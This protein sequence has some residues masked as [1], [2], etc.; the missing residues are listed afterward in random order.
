MIDPAIRSAWV[1][2]LFAEKLTYHRML[3]VEKSLATV[4]AELGLI[5]TE[6]ATAIS[7]LDPDT[8]LKV[9]ELQASF[10]T[11]GFPVVGLVRSIVDAAPDNL[12]QY[13]HW[14][15]TTQDIMDTALVLGLRDVL[16][17][18]DGVLDRTRAHFTALSEAHAA[19]LMAG[20]SQLQQAVPITFGYKA[21]GWIDALERSRSRLRDLGPRLLVVQ[22]GGAVGTMAALHPNGAKVR[23][24]LAGALGLGD[25]AIA[26]HTHRDAL[27]DFVCDLGILSGTLTKIAG[28]IVLMAQTEIGEVQE[29]IV[30]G[31]GISSTMPHKRNP[32]LSQQIMVAARAVRGLVPV[33][34]EAM[35]Q[36]HERGSGTWQNEW[37]LIPN[38]CSHTM[39]ALERMEE[40]AAGLYVNPERMTANIGLSRQFVYAEAVMMALAGSLGRQRAHDLVEGVVDRAIGG[41]GFKAALLADSDVAAVLTAED[42]ERIFTGD[43]HRE[44]GRA[45]T[46]HALRRLG[47]YGG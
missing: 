16:A 31:R 43:L 38:V 9:R 46:E 25:P 4:Q 28:D 17:R 5:P 10:R 47:R 45:A 35:V 13:A 33:M 7:A 32:V 3:E 24:R 2:E 14:G 34:L 23:A 11:I 21:A 1:E 19:T 8:V 12:G 42:L 30:A 20:R 44:A 22:M 36:D 41:A 26:W 39:A 15:A 18:I 37:G 40:L 6:A 29:P 27:A